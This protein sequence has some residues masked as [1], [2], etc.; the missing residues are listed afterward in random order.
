MELSQSSKQRSLS[1][2]SSDHISSSHIRLIRC[3]HIRAET[4][5]EQPPTVQAGW[6]ESKVNVTERDFDRMTWQALQDPSIAERAALHAHAMNA[7]LIGKDFVIPPGPG[8]SSYT[9]GM[10][11]HGL[12]AAIKSKIPVSRKYLA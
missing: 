12:C 2:E 4:L 6:D 7:A 3:A 5:T 8:V 11:W 1:T 10:V 9:P